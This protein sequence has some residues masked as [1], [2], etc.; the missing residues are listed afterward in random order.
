MSKKESKKAI[1]ADPEL[2]AAFAANDS[3]ASRIE[4]LLIAILKELQA[5][6]KK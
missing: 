3:Q 1:E 2:A 4:I 6:N 5:L